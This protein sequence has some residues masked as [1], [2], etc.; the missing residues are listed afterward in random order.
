[1]AL[2]KM[3][4]MKGLVDICRPKNLRCLHNQLFFPTA[5]CYV[6]PFLKQSTRTIGYRDN[7]SACRR[8]MATSA[9]QAEKRDDDWESGTLPSFKEDK[10]SQQHR[11]K[12][13][14]YYSVVIGSL[15]GLFGSCYMLYERIQVISI[16]EVKAETAE[17]ESEELAESE[18]L[19][20]ETA[21][22]QSEEGAETAEIESG[23]LHKSDAGFKEKKIIEYENRLRAY[24]TPDKIFRYFADVSFSVNYSIK[25]I[26]SNN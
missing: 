20:A 9:K 11:K 4:N 2:S 17:I 26:I 15:I 8:L 18:E 7:A 23:S 5:K 21:E 6:S 22:V 13:A 25:I 14:N 10:Y 19:K 3:K 24:S 16:E 1:M 12:M